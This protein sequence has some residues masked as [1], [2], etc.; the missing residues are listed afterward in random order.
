FNEGAA[1][2]RTKERKNKATPRK[3]LVLFIR[4]RP[5]VRNNVVS[6]SRVNCAQVLA[7]FFPSCSDLS[8]LTLCHNAGL[9]NVSHHIE[10][11]IVLYHLILFVL[12][13]CVVLFCVVLFILFQALT[14]ARLMACIFSFSSLTLALLSLEG[15]AHLCVMILNSC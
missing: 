6:C 14:N 1:E 9:W 3:Q 4:T 10:R 5:K 2:N 11:T 15:S 12:L 8:L 7:P 13:F